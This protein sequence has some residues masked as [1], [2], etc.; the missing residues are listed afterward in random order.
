[1]VTPNVVTVCFL[2]AMTDLRASLRRNGISS[3]LC[4][5]CGFG[6]MRD[7]VRAEILKNRDKGVQLSCQ[8]VLKLVEH[9]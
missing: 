4:P 3:G 1:M 2:A 6:T 8:E 5:S 7:L 9:G